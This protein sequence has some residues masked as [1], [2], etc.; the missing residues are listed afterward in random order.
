MNDDV[1]LGIIIIML[2]VIDEDDGNNSELIYSLEDMCIGE[3]NGSVEEVIK[4][5]VIDFKI[6]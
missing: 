1:K 5:F 4:W 6:G 3:C 2:M